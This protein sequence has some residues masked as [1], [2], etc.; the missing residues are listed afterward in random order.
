MEES[1]AEVTFLRAERLYDGRGVV[2]ENAAV[3]INR[4]GR[5]TR[6]GEGLEPRPGSEV[7][8][9]RGAALLPGLVDC[10][11][12]LAMDA[13]P[14]WLEISEASPASLAL[15][16]SDA[17]EQTLAGGVT[18]AR[19]LG[20]PH[21]VELAVR[22]AVATGMIV[23]PRLLCAGRVICP[24]GG[25]GSWMGRMADGP[26]AVRAA[27]RSELAAG[28]DFI[29]VIASGGVLTPG[30]R[31]AGSAFTYE[32]LS[33]CVDEAHRL[34]ASV[35]AHALTTDAVSD[36]VRA[37]CDGIEH[38]DGM[39]EATAHEMR[40]RGV[41]LGATLTSA[42]DFLCASDNH[43]APSWALE[44]LKATWPRRVDA[45]R[46]AVER[47]VTVVMSTD[48]G[49]PFHEHGSN[50]AE[51]A[52][53]AENGLGPLAALSAATYEG[54]RALGLGDETGS[55]EPGKSADIIA[56]P[57]SAIEDT[58]LFRSRGVVRFV[59][60]GGVRYLPR[61]GTKIDGHHSFEGRPGGMEE[62]AKG[63]G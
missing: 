40:D 23:G 25:H 16:A 55:L 57:A 53:M 37:G 6:V 12:H 34:G 63:N 18:T 50:C 43:A 15:R 41:V 31:I 20:A 3:G 9:L 13:R 2:I 60:R 8:D 24:T 22:D 11:V 7:M 42:S 44:K 49:T 61:A 4:A 58:S 17:A 47:G 33:A 21:G 39:D 46:A 30:S 14:S 26:D 19:C 52:A 54:A 45:F 36:A 27:V 5:L 29:K 62:G 38:G 59:M 35:V 32:E 56:V 48:A 10:H 51:I 28:A 1:D